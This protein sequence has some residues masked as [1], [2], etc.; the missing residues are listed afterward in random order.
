MNIGW[1][2]GEINQETTHTD[3]VG[4]SLCW[5]VLQIPFLCS[6]T[7]ELGEEIVACLSLPGSPHHW[8]ETND[9]RR[10][11]ISKMTS[12]MFRLTSK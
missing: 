9:F 7:H 5:L 4:L 6:E 1:R 10:L 11:L 3:H 12:R 2:Y 8:L